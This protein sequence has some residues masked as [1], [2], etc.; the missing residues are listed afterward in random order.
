MPKKKGTLV[1]A[2]HVEARRAAE[3][4]FFAIRIVRRASG[5][6]TQAAGQ[7]VKSFDPDADGGRGK[8]TA[9]ASPQHAKRF[10]CWGDVID[11]RDRPAAARAGFIGP[12]RPMLAFVIEI[13]LVVDRT[14][15]PS[16][17]S[18]V[19]EAAE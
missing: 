5:R 19:L 10:S 14:V 17:A 7:Y 16:V 1:I 18:D 4:E 11:Y 13:V 8:L 6:P 15:H 2:S 3:G 9:T 12:Y